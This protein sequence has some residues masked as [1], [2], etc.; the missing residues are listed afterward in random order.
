MSNRAEIA[1][2]LR[3]MPPD[4]KRQYNAGR[5][6][7][8]EN[9]GPRLPAV[10]TPEQAMQLI[11][12]TAGGRRS[13]DKPKGQHRVP[14]K[15][16]EDAMLGIRLS[17]EHNY[18]AWNFIGLARAIQLALSPG[19]PDST[20]KRMRNYFTRH[21]KDKSSR[22]F[23]SKV[24]PSRGYMA[25]LNWGGDA[26]ARWVGSRKQTKRNPEQAVRYI[27]VEIPMYAAYAKTNN[28]W[29]YMD[30]CNPHRHRS[31]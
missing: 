17:Y 31:D 26:G 15:V 4:W 18:G 2:M 29:E 8:A 23:G 19:V 6:Q 7:L 16:R 30:Y 3:N 24:S 10:P 13:G 27:S 28:T 25:W 11:G 20:T 9:G 21:I 22:K 5:K 1:Q 14:A 12:I